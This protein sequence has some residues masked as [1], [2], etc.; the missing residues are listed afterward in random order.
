MEIL[1]SIIKNKTCRKIATLNKNTTF[2]YIKKNYAN[3]QILWRME[4]ALWWNQL[5]ELIQV[6]F[7][8]LHSSLCNILSW[9]VILINNITVHRPDPFFVIFSLRRSVCAL[10]FVSLLSTRLQL[11]LIVRCWDEEQ[12]KCIIIFTLSL[13]LS[14]FHFTSP[15]H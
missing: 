13:F 15:V 4:S 8:M 3:P 11:F 1:Y 7:F 10:R 2:S 12:I 14:D 6:I 9:Y 5:S